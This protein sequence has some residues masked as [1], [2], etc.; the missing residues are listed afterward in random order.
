MTADPI[1]YRKAK[2][3]YFRRVIL[4]FKRSRFNYSKVD[5]S[6]YFIAHLFLSSPSVSSSLL[7][8]FLFFL[9]TPSLSIRLYISLSFLSFSFPLHPLSLSHLSP[10]LPFISLLFTPLLSPPLL[11]FPIYPPLFSFSFLFPPLLP[12]SFLYPFSRRR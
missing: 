9:S 1:S 10:L 8:L 2:A 6:R 11:F 4:A 5:L 3:S 7:F 12:S